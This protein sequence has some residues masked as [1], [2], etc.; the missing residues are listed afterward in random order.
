LAEA[1]SANAFNEIVTRPD[2]DGLESRLSSE[3]QAIKAEL[4]SG[5]EDL[6]LR[7]TIRMR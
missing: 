2:L 4:K 6:E 5:I 1:L 3:A 7:F